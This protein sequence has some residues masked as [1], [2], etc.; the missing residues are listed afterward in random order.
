M[1]GQGRHLNTYLDAPHKI[2]MLMTL[3]WLS[4]IQY[5]VQ[6]SCFRDITYKFKMLFNNMLALFME[7]V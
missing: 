3:Q 5:V 6:F 1:E 7:H 4:L 2:H